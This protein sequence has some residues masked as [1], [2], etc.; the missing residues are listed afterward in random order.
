M[1]KRIFFVFAAMGLGSLGCS[2]HVPEPTEN[3]PAPTA[4][5]A[6]IDEYRHT[7]A[8][9]RFR[10]G[11]NSTWVTE[12]HSRKVSGSD[13]VFVEDS[14]NGH[15]MAILNAHSTARSVPSFGATLAEHNAEVRSYFVR[16]GLPEREI[17]RVD[18]SVVTSGTGRAIDG[19]RA[20]LVGAQKVGFISTIR[21]AVDGIP[22]RDSI[23]VAAI[24][25]DGDV[26]ME[27]V[28]W[29][30][31][32]PAIVREAKALSAVINASN[33]DDYLAKLP[34]ADEDRAGEVVIRHT[35]FHVEEQPR[36][37]AT[38]ER[39]EKVQNSWVL[40]RYDLSGRQL[41]WGQPDAKGA[42]TTQPKQP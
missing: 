41:S 2:A 9:S 3:N 40:R 32:D 26:T 18:G 19:I 24:N 7:I 39:M 34:H 33:A 28:Y 14:S 10:V 35:A 21:R 30:S 37:I 20:E 8:K 6:Q 25:K 27:T 12:G 16:S 29:P 38:F 42:L 31:I 1:I 36:T 23:A 22:V 13:G 17:D 15:V 4:G 11:Q 5:V